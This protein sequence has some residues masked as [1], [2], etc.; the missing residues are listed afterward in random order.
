MAFWRLKSG[1]WRGLEAKK[2]VKNTFL[3]QMKGGNKS[4]DGV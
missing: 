2:G 4:P 1:E 3:K